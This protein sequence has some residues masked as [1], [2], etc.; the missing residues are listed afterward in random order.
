MTAC[1]QII[2][3]ALQHNQRLLCLCEG[4][5]EEKSVESF[6]P[7]IPMLLLWTVVAAERLL[8]EGL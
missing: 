3:R 8:N 2:S 6:F 1:F 5:S 4:L 7:T